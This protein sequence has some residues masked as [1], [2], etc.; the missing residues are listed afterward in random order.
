MRVCIFG[1]SFVHGVG[2]DEA[3]GWVGR[4]CA[5]ERRRGAD[6]TLYNL[7]VRGDTSE[8][9]HRR[10]R[11]EAGARMP[12]GRACG[13]VFAFGANDTAAGPDGRPRLGT[14][15]T[16]AASRA[17]L[18]TA[19]DWRPTLMIG[20]L[21]VTDSAGRNGR[22]IQLSQA[23]AEICEA[24][25]VPFLSTVPFAQ[26]HGDLW[27]REAM[28]GDGVHPSRGAYTALAEY[29]GAWSGWRA[30]FGGA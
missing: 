17:I 3:L 29:I 12:D 24:L 26:T 30:W 14:A 1:D 9:V 4:V 18:G 11:A 25:A 16:L 20:P 21:P 2:D 13:V 15:D 8:D 23:I 10:W 22:L 6:L 19:Q 27:R 28:Q 5:A 7:G